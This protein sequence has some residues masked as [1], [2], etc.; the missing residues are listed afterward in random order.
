MPITTDPARLTAVANALGDAVRSAN[1]ARRVR[2]PV[3]ERRDAAG[4]TLAMAAAFD[5]AIDER[6]MRIE[7]EGHVLA[8][9]Q[10]CHHCCVSPLVVSEPEAVAV[11]EWLSL[12]QNAAARASFA[13]AYPAWKRQAG[14]EGEAVVK[15]SNNDERRT[16]AIAYT[17]K[18][19]MCALNQAGKC[20]IYPARPARCR[21][22]HA[23]VDNTHC[24]Q[25]GDGIIQYYDHPRTQEMFDEQEDIRGAMHAAMRQN[26]DYELLCSAVE[27]LLGTSSSIGR[28]ELC[29]CGSGKKYKRCCA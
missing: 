28:N 15:A 19:V 1:G 2:L 29:P 27:R 9:E 26:A 4:L 23:L 25:H 6:R 24:G 18:G 14:A 11:A 22:A 17:R 12:P 16:A 7:D 21:M 10:G 8:C 13:A 5:D 3:L 20:T